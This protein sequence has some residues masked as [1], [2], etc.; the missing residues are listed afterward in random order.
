MITDLDIALRYIM[1]LYGVTATEAK[2]SYYKDELH[3]AI[4]L[5]RIGVNPWTIADKNEKKPELDWTDDEYYEGAWSW[6]DEL[7][8]KYE[9]NT[10]QDAL[11]ELNKINRLEII[12]QTGRAYTHHLTKNESVRYSLQ[13]DNLTLKIFIANKGDKE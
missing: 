5:I 1:T 11:V 3:E 2:S 10:L 9:D 6:V 8:L 7:E 4:N 13:D 12:D